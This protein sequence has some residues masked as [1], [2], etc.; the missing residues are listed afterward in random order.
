MNANKIDLTGQTF[1]RLLVLSE[2]DR[3]KDRQI[4]W[5]CIC[6]CGNIKKVRSDH[7]RNGSIASCGCLKQ[8]LT[9]LRQTTHGQRTEK[10]TSKEY[11]CWCH[12]KNRCYDLNSAAYKNYGGRGITV[13][14]R[15]LNSFENFY[16]DMG[17]CPPGLMIERKNNNGNYTPGNCVWAT[18]Q[19]QG[20]NRRTNKWI[21][22]NGKIKTVAQW[23]RY[24]GINVN[25]LYTR[26]YVGWSDK[27]TLTTPV[28]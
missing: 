12:M 22:F 8:E 6:S 20:N 16:E 3:G 24:L 14:D 28:R 19:E 21:K 15:W 25:T 2:A 23:A 7:L 18:P 17:N 13:C 4:Y 9:V 1:T 11:A 10:Y 26:L 27:M 5:N